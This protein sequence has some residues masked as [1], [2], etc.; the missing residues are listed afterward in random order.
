MV[1]VARY[2]YHKTVYVG[3]KEDNICNNIRKGLDITRATNYKPEDLIMPPRPAKVK[4]SVRK[5][6]SSS[7]KRSSSYTNAPLPL[8]K[9]TCSGSPP[10]GRRRPT[11]LNQVHQ[12]V[13]TRDYGKPLYEASSRAAILAALEGGIEGYK[14]S[15]TRAG[16]VQ[17]DILTGNLMMNKEDN[18][19]SWPVFLIDFNLAIK[20]QREGPSGARG[21]TGIRAFM[22]IR[23]LLGEIYL[24]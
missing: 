19:P 22:A 16:I 11:T 9:R 15:Y 12:R 4:I 8:S 13:I 24:A 20:E 5:G 21:K 14:S 23:V 18:N 3:G 2:Y 10:K 6:R 17:C 1:N 7:R